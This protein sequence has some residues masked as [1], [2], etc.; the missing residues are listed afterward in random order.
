MNP[1]R[2]DRL[3]MVV[4]AGRFSHAADIPNAQ[5]KPVSWCA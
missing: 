2:L 3:V 1:G 4:Q 5:M